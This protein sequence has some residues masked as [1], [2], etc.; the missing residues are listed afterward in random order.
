MGKIVL[1][2]AGQGSQYT[3]MGKELSD[4][5][6]AA[7]AVFDMVDH[8][9]PGTS[10]LCF[11]GQKDALDQTVNTQPCVFAVDLAAAAQ[12]GRQELYRILQLV[13]L[14]GKSQL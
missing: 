7:K 11:T 14:W 5:S 1:M 3:G 4:C 2:F 8:I 10:A 6:K 9:R 13:F 12:S